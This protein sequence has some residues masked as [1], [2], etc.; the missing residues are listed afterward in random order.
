M[1]CPIGLGFSSVLVWKQ[2]YTLP[3]LVW[4]RVWFL[5]ELR[6]I[7]T[8]LLFQFQMSK[9]ERKI[10]E[11]E[12]PLKNSL[13]FVCALMS[14]LIKGQ[15]WK[16]VWILEVC[17]L[18]WKR[19]WKVCWVWNYRVR[20]WRTGRHKTRQCYIYLQSYAVLRGGSKTGPGRR[21]K[22]SLPSL[23]QKKGVRFCVDEEWHTFFLAKDFTLSSLKTYSTNPTPTP[24]LEPL[25]PTSQVIF[26]SLRSSPL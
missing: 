18:V 13:S 16:Q 7:W 8:F 23:R 24:Y 17:R 26:A 4:N 6:S 15:V 20:V 5:R 12:M 10:C 25:T 1:C 14:I 19:V 2:V 21:R 22:S 9:K 3:I 11:F